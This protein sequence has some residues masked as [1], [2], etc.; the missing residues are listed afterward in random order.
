MTARHPVTDRWLAGDCEIDCQT[1]CW[2]GCDVGL[3]DLTVP[4]DD[5]LTGAVVEARDAVRRDVD[6][7]RHRLGLTPPEQG[8]EA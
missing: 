8:V 1:V 6:A 2:G 7:A 3:V 4:V 5:G